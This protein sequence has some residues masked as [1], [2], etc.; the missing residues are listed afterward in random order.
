MK[1]KKN[2]GAT[3]TRRPTHRRPCRPHFRDINKSHIIDATVTMA[4]VLRDR[5]RSSDNSLVK[6]VLSTYCM[7]KE[8]RMCGEQD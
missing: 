8:L 3:E 5:E 4:E 6:H 7:P 2:N 1:K